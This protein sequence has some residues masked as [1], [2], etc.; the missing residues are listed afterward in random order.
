[1][2]KKLRIFIIGILISVIVFCGIGCQANNESTVEQTTQNDSK[3]LT[4]VVV[5]G[6]SYSDNGS[7]KENTTLIMKSADKPEGARLKPSDPDNDEKIYW[8][9]RFSNGLTSV[10]VLAEKL[11]VELKNYATGGATTGYKNYAPWMDHLKDTGVLGQIDEFEGSLDGK[12][13][14]AN[15]LYLIFA[16]TNDYYVFMDYS[17]PGTIEE[18]ADKSVENINTAVRKLA[19]LGAEKF[20]IVNSPDLSTLPWEIAYDQIESASAFTQRVNSTLPV[21][22]EKLDSELGIEIIL[23]DHTAVSDK[24]MNNPESYGFVEL[25]KECQST[26]PEFKPA[27]ENPDEY[28]FWDEWHFS[29]AAHKIFGEEMYTCLVNGK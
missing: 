12:K 11:E 24:I 25:E 19:E 17:L 7:A 15:A 29:R 23:F 2:S 13:A 21:T 18:I 27:A 6:D 20:F 28:Y 1:M 8:E 10:E 5:F 26:Y 9:N 22:V 14:D 3:L 4:E 16:S